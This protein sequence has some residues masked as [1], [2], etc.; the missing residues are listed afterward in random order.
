MWSTLIGGAVGLTG[1]WL[2]IE[3][4][5]LNRREDVGRYFVYPVF[6][7]IATIAGAVVGLC[8]DLS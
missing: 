7:P 2:L 8:F 6:I 5:Y 3:I 1:S 4:S